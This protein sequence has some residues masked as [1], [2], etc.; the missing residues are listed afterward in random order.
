MAMKTPSGTASERG[1]LSSCCRSEGQPVPKYLIAQARQIGR[2]LMVPLFFS[3]SVIVGCVAVL[4][5]MEP[6]VNDSVTSD[7]GLV[8]GRIHLTDNG[9]ESHASSIQSVHPGF[10]IQWRIREQTIGKEFLIDG[11]PSDGPFVVKLPTGSY[12]LTALSFDT[13]AGI[14]Q[15]SLPANFTVAPRKCTYLGTWE[16]RTRAG[17]FDGSINR[18]VLN[19]Y[20]LAESDLQAFAPNGLVPQLVSQLSPSMESPLIL[21]FRPQGTELTSPP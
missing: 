19:Q 4:T 3:L 14:W 8:L 16:L 18:E 2:I 12:R 9:S 10:R 17:F 15:A 1:V 21:T 13:A 20:G 7:E 11:L 6:G 5:P